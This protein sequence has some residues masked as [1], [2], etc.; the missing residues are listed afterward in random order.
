[1]AH[2][3]ARAEA[4]RKAWLAQASRWPEQPWPGDDETPNHAANSNRPGHE[5]RVP[6]HDGHYAEQ[7][8]QPAMSAVDSLPPAYVAAINAHGYVDVYRAY[9]RRIPVDRIRE[10]AEKTGA[11][12]VL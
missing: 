8:A 10:R 3:S 4:A 11:L 2:R 5:Q 9:L 6:A 12:F 7:V 1:M